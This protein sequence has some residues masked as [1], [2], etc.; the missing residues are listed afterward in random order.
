MTSPARTSSGLYYPNRF[1]LYLFSAMQEVMGQ[2]G[3]DSTLAAAGLGHYTTRP[4]EN[5][6]DRAIDFADLAALNAALDEVYGARGG[7]GM[8]LRTGRVWFAQWLKDFGALRGVGHPAFRALPL[9]K[10]CLLGLEALAAVFNQ[11]SDQHCR[12]EEVEGAYHFIVEHSPTAWGR[13]ADKPICQPLV[14]MLQEAMRWFSNGR[15]YA[16][17]ETHCRACGADACLF[18]INKRPL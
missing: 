9:E 7:R 17:R 4:P 13:T 10:R 16:V 14:G 12:I 2:H 3:L 8:A 6:L 1:L 18:V 11:F 15:D 5:T